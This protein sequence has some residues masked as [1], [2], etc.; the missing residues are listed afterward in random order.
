MASKQQR[1]FTLVELSLVMAFF[2]ILLIGVLTLTIHVGKLYT[3][4]MTNKSLNTVG[5]DITDVLRR[6]FAA[7][8]AQDIQIIGEQGAVGVQH[9][10]MCLGNVSYVWNTVGLLNAPSSVTRITMGTT[11]VKLVRVVDTARSYCT[12]SGGNYPMTVGATETAVDLLSDDEASGKRDFAA[13][14]V[15][16]TPAGTSS[17]D[18]VYRV[19][20]TLG[21]Y[22]PNTTQVI[23]SDN[24]C[25]PP[26]DATANFEYC[27]VADFD[28]YVRVGGVKD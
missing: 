2:S 9:G 21:T 23:G 18:G 5:R 13:Y 25:R 20:F 15:I 28:M 14:H 16:V 4:G 3:K 7:A 11:R 1:G 26:T 17:S 19:Q 27:S 12:P 8:N 22:D 10:R 6:D 24:T